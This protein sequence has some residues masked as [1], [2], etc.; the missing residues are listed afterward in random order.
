M[1]NTYDNNL[2]LPSAGQADWDT[3]LNANFTLLERGFTIRAMAGAV[4]ATG[5]VVSQNSAGFMLAHNPVSFDLFIPQ[6][7][8]YRRVNSGEEAYF[9]RSGIVRSLDILSPSVPGQPMFASASGF[10]VG[11]YSGAAFPIGVGIGDRAVYFD[12]GRFFQFTEKLTRTTTVTVSTGTA[13]NFSLDIGKRGWI[14]QLML[15]GA[16]ADLMR[17]RLWSNSTRA[18]SELLYETKSGGISVVGSFIDQ[19]GFPYENTIT[20][21]ISGLVFG[22]LDVQTGCVVNTDTIGV[23]LVA[24]RHR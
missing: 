1:S 22:Q 14:R 3:D 16:S 10:A 6:Y 11:S 24:E 9:L 21:S 15:Q 18:A 17:V 7:F 20:S 23:T 13:Q 4:V 19:A 2:S 12:P 5:A 8:A